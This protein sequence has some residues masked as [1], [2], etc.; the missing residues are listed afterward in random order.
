MAQTKLYKYVND[1]NGTP[2][3]IRK[4]HTELSILIPIDENN[5]DYREV[6]E[7]VAEGNTIEEAD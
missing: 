7:W 3:N 4:K 6:L 2:I 5:S 1:A